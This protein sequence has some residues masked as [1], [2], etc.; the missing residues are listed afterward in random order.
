MVRSRCLLP[1]L[2]ALAFTMPS[3]GEAQELDT[4]VFLPDTLGSA[5]SP[6][7]ILPN[8]LTGRVYVVMEGGVSVFD[9]A[10]L[11]K[12]RYFEVEWVGDAEF[13]PGADKMYVLNQDP[14]AVV[15]IDANADTILGSVQI[16]EDPGVCLAYSRT[17]RK[18]YVGCEGD[19]LFAIDATADTVARKIVGI[20]PV[21]SLVWDSVHNRVL[22]S[23]WDDFI[24]AV[25]CVADTVVGVVGLQTD[26]EAMA[27]NP[28]RNKLYA[29]DGDSSVYVV[30][31]DQLRLSAVIPV[32]GVWYKL[33]YNPVSERVYA[34]SESAEPDRLAI[35]DCVAD[36]V[37]SILPMGVMHDFAYSSATG[38][39]YVAQEDTLGVAILD[40]SDS[41]I[42]RL[43]AGTTR[44]FTALG[45]YP[46]RNE[47]YC[48]MNA[49]TVTIVDTRAD[50]VTGY[51]DYVRF[52]IH[53]M[54]FNPAGRKLYLLSSARDAIQ[55]MGPDQSVVGYME[56]DRLN[57]DAFPV[58]HPGLNRLY[59]ADRGWLR[60]ID[61]N[62]DQVLDSTD[63]GDIRDAIAVLHPDLNK[64]YIFPEDARSRDVSIWMYDCL[65]NEL[66]EVLYLGQETHCAAYHP[67]SDR[68]YF[69]PRD[70]AR[71]Y[72]L[73]PISDSVVDSIPIG[74]H[75]YDSRMV[76]DTD[77][78]RLYYFPGRADTLFTIDVLTDSV[79]NTTW[80]PVRIDTIIWNRHYSKLYLSRFSSLTG[81]T[82]V[83]DCLTQAVID[84]FPD[85][86]L[87]CGLM[88][89]RTDRL[90]LGTTQGIM[91]VD[92]RTDSVVARLPEMARPRVA[93]VDLAENKLFFTPRGPWYAV[94]QDGPVGIGEFGIGQLG[95]GV[96]LLGNPASGRVR[97]H[98]LVPPGNRA[99]LQVFDAVGRRVLN[100]VVIG[101]ESPSTF[102]W[103]RKDASGRDVRSGVYLVRL[104][105]AGRTATRKL[106]IQN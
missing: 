42:G 74:F 78:D 104:S 100:K 19:T 86:T 1:V 14:A 102:V 6:L 82:Y 3:I 37:R 9:P 49:D 67:R 8:P 2:L 22:V 88:N 36:T 34:Q 65:S 98:Y 73:D 16:G 50:T 76:A 89:E 4:L 53:G 20:P 79:V 46:D 27:L 38:H 59:V 103:D 57:Y 84:S 26:A 54:V 13:C 15:S 47:L 93:A 48:G 18:L 66:T 70:Y 64:L 68:I 21:N 40:H 29:G 105:A 10:T 58:I 45:V 12:A 39:V 33:M 17:S 61:C 35:I 71:L 97:I 94:Y 77:L 101:R 25:D 91:V 51:M 31:T 7:K 32:L 5:N 55:V 69:D 85:T 11:E 90:Y 83:F 44:D 52:Y 72:V 24:A 28:D 92:C 62:I 41:V 30:D 95:F 56:F 63:I 80:L 43:F 106:V 99:V 81:K 96:R 23:T 60:V 87:S 75:G